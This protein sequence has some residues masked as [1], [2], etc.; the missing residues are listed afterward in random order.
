MTAAALLLAIGGCATAE[1]PGTGEGPDARRIDA[2][3]TDGS[4]TDGPLPTDGS[5]TDARVIDARIIDAPGCVPVTMQR[6]VNPSFDANPVGTGWVETLIDPMYPLITADDGVPE[7]S[8]PYKLWMGGL[9]SGDDEA[10]QDIL[11]PAG[12]TQ[13]LLR[14]Q[15]DVRTAEI[16]GVFD[17]STVDLTT[18]GNVVLQNAL[19]VDNED[20]TTGWTSFQRIFPQTYAGQTV[21]L[22]IRSHNDVSEET[23]FFYD[24]LA[25]EATVCQ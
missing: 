19:A 9:P 23:S 20:D 15:Y 16:F 22:R 11:I 10:R 7:H 5:V 25:L 18:P 12:T 8:A 2:R 21:R 24:S 3:V 14:G 1:P 17:T 13:L 4:V 6:L